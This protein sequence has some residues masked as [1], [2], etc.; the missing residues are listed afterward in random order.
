MQNLVDYLKEFTGSTAVYVGK[1]TKPYK[2]IS[3]GDDD[4]AH[5]NP[6]APEHI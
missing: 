4:T 3:D 6:A 1:L 2:K 5:L